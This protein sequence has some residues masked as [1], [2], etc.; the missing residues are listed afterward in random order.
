MTLMRNTSVAV[1]V[2]A[3]L[4][5]A[6]TAGAVLIDVAGTD[7][8]T[9][10]TAGAP[11]EIDSQSDGSAAFVTSSANP[12]LA[13]AEIEFKLQ[14]DATPIAPG[15][16][17]G[18]LW[19]GA[20]AGGADVLIIDPGTLDVLVALEVNSLEGGNVTASSPGNV[21]NSFTLG[22]LDELDPKSDLSITGGTL[23][24]LFGGIGNAAHLQLTI[25]NIDTTITAP[26]FG[27]GLLNGSF[28]G[29]TNVQIGFVA[30]PEPGTG[31]LL[32]TALLGLAGWR[33]GRR[34]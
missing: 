34:S 22:S 11:G 24:G 1:A 27:F 12:A 17:L 6:P 7:L 2:A 5:V 8:A 20:N 19:S 4:L 21:L 15:T 14:L 16:A 29:T 9:A 28:G 32:G 13:G 26:P 31:M 10:Y 3:C 33:R 25:T 23:A 18:S 30:T